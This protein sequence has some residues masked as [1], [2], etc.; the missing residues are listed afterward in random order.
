MYSRMRLAR[1]GLKKPGRSLSDWCF[2][3]AQEQEQDTTTMVV[4]FFSM[5]LRQITPSDLVRRGRKVA[6]Q[7]INAS[8]RLLQNNETMLSK[9]SNE[10]DNV[11]RK[12]DVF[13]EYFGEERLIAYY[14]TGLRI[15]GEEKLK[16]QKRVI[17]L[18]R[19]ST[20]L[21]HKC[22]EFIEF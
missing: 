2:P 14:P 12:V 16:E 7:T 3:C 4:S 17:S 1:K 13:A 18:R 22:T 21:R 11:A 5:P 8:K 15:L 19:V 6:I 20:T 10:N 9:T